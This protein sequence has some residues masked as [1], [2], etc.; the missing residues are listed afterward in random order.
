MHNAT[1]QQLFTEGALRMHMSGLNPVEYP[2]SEYSEYGDDNSDLE[3]VHA[4]KVFMS[5][6]WMLTINILILS[7]L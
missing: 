1:S 7:K 3:G 5:L 4:W 6:K 2:N